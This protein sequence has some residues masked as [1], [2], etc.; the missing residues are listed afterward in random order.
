MPKTC[1]IGIGSPFGADR[2][3]WLAIEALRQRKIAQDV[4]LLQCRQP[5]ALT[6]MLQG[7]ERVILL[8]ALIAGYEL[9][10]VVQCY[11]PNL[12]ANA[13][14]LSSH[15]IGVDQALKLAQVLGFLPKDVLVLG[16]EVGCVDQEISPDWLNSLANEVEAQ[17]A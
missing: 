15:G 2:L 6:N 12:L 14:K 11:L 5:A 7:Y 13:S 16:L 10:S 3:G 1:V 17:L 9:G 8:D 4:P